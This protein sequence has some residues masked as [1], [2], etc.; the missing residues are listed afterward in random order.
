MGWLDSPL[1]VHNGNVD[2]F[3]DQRDISLDLISELG[4]Y[5][6]EAKKDKERKFSSIEK[7]AKS[8]RSYISAC[9]NFNLKESYLE[10]AVEL[11]FTKTNLLKLP[12]ANG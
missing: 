2:A 8:K 5:Y 3:F 1:S 4:K 10:R 9:E 12:Q 7:S 6:L 11:Y